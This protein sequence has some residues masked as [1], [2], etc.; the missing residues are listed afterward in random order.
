MSQQVYCNVA[1]SNVTIPRH[2]EKRFIVDKIQTNRRELG[3]LIREARERK[4]YSQDG[5]AR[6]V[7]M[8]RQQIYRIENAK[9]GTSKET[10]LKIAKVLGIDERKIL[11]LI[12][13][14]ELSDDE[15]VA[16]GLFSGYYELDE[17][18]RKLARKQIAAIIR[19]FKDEDFED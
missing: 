1:T 5:L 13:G 17:D 2:Q 11:S 18:Q 6:L 10:G 3:D 7:E 15:L 19:S 4:K 9:S 8:E 12:A 14:M 16:D